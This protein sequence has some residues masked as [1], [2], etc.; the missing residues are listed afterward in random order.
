MAMPLSTG[1]HPGSHPT[2]KAWCVAFVSAATTEL[3][4]TVSTARTSTRTTHGRQQSLGT[5]MP[6]RPAHSIST[7]LVLLQ[8]PAGA[9]PRAASLALMPVISPVVPITANAL[10]LDGTAAVVW[11]PPSLLLL[12]VH[13][14]Q[15]PP[16]VGSG[17]DFRDSVSLDMPPPCQAPKE[18]LPLHQGAGCT[19]WTGSDFARVVDGAG[20]SLLAPIVPS[21]LE[22]DIV[23]RY[24]TQVVL[25]P[26]VKGLPGLRSVDPGATGHLQEL[27]KAGCV[28]AARM[29]LSSTIPEAC[30]RLVCS[31]SALFQGGGLE[32][33]CHTKGATNAICNPVN[34]QCPCWAGLAGRCCDHC[35]YGWW[36]FPCCQPCACSG[37]AELCHPLTGVCQDCHGATMDQHCERCL[38]GYYGDPTLGSGQQCWPCL[39]PGHPG[40]GI[41]HGTSCHVDSTSGCVLCLCASGYAGPRCDR[42]SLGY[43]GHPWPGDDPRRSLCQPCQCNN[44]IDPVIQPPVTPTVDTAS[45]VSTTAMALAVPT[46]G[47]ASKA[48]PCTKGAAGMSV[49]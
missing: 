24:E 11:E 26:Q 34:G 21:A 40:S 36:G 9:I 33:C 17:P 42:C 44:N 35:L 4:P 2:W 37:A 43:F 32:C 25:L 15:G 3:V 12:T 8:N 13:K 19:L 46:A 41:Y 31:I 47:L 49:C 23:L 7:F 14:P 30:A 28:E 27:H 1:L 5:P 48:V 16:L 22:C 18:P 20:L 10:S 39:C 38:D 29:S 6:A 45:T